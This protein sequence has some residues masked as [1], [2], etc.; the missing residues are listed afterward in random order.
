MRRWLIA[1]ILFCL[2]LLMAGCSSDTSA[3][4]KKS[5]DVDL[6]ILSDTVAYS[7][8]YDMLTYPENYIG[9]T[10]KMKGRFAY[11]YDPALNKS[12]YACVVMDATACCSQG[13]EFVLPESYVY[14]DDYPELD[15]EICVCG[16]FDTYTENNCM[17]CTLRDASLLTSDG[18]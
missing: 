6:T 7:Q 4:T 11:F 8:V 18:L 15:A 16:T 3:E 1:L 13:I 9:K 14:P 17:Y 10:V 5:F 12:Y 2:I